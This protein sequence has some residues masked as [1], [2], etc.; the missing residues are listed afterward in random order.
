MYNNRAKCYR[1]LNN[2][3][4]ALLDYNSAIEACPKFALAVYNRG[5]CFQ[6]M[7]EYFNAIEDFSVCLTIDPTS[8][9]DYWERRAQCYEALGMKQLV[10]D[11]YSKLLNQL[12]QGDSTEERGE[13]Q[14][15]K[16]IF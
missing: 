7:K 11:D 15:E 6:A 14:K 2:L 3:Q 1:K 13:S 12:V 5:L 4:L 16:K 9:V 10:I 8:S